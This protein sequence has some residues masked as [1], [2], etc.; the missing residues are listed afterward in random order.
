M[1]TSTSTLELVA[2]FRL[3]AMGIL[4][5]VLI[6]MLSIFITRDWIRSIAFV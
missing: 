2:V 5:L 6:L 4:M 3:L 1:E